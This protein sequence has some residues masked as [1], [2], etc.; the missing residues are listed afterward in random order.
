MFKDFN[1]FKNKMNGKKAVVVGV[2][3][4][5]TPLIKLLCSCGAEVTACD[6]KSADELGEIYNE[7]AGLG[8][9]FK[10]GE[11][12]LS[13]LEGD[14]LFKTPGLRFDNENLIKFS[15]KGG[16]VTSEMEVFFD[17]C[18]SKIIAITGSDG[19]TTT[20][21]LISE[22]LKEQ[23]YNVH[24]G[25]NIGK[26]LL[27]ETPEIKP[28]DFTVV[29]LSSFQLQTMKKSADV[30]VITNITP[31]HLDYHKS[32]EEYTEAKKNVYKFQ[33]ENG[34]LV[35]NFDNDLTNEIG[36][37]EKRNIRYFSRNH[38]L[39]DGVWLDCKTVKDGENILIDI[40]R[41]KLPGLHNVE[42]FMTA[43]QAVKDFISVETFVKV[44]EE[45]GGVKHR[46]EFVRELN[47]VSFYNDSIASSPT[48]AQALID[49]FYE[50]GTK[51]TII[52]GGYDKKIPFDEFGS[53]IVKKVKKAYLVGHTAE[54][55]AAAIK[56]ADSNYDYVILNTLKEAVALAYN[57]AEKGDVVALCPACA[58]F[59]F[60]KNFEERGNLFKK[61]VGEL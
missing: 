55:I 34:I 26:P 57:E 44:A 20:T 1:D 58:S 32:M 4:S 5:N 27:C 39:K 16:T 42:N 9:Q 50:K 35:L 37:S 8:V 21:T 38:A 36:K 49:S 12:Y 11:S 47:G 33:N 45:F 6:K 23:G 40:E 25:G 22:M 2:G 59:D 31:N 60:Y 54:K 56:N 43:Y 51:A 17:V 61:L 28:E 52:C 46:I 19:K 53:E 7:L 15:K 3:V 48:R 41:I 29:E 30:A 24:L 18:P 13:D 14:Y 10:L